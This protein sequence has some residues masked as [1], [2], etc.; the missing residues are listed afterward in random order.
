MRLTDDLWPNGAE[1]ADG[2]DRRNLLLLTQLR[3]LAALGQIMTILVVHFGVGVDLPLTQMF[4]MVAV[5]AAHNLVSLETY[6]RRIPLGKSRM[7]IELLIDVGAF[8]VQIY[9]SGG[10]TNP[11]ITLFLLQVIIGSILLNVW[12]AWFLF[13]VAA[14][15]FIVLCEFY[16]PLRAPHDEEAALLNLHTQGMLFCF[17][18][19]SSLLVF[20]VTRMN[21]NLRA[22]DA[23]LAELRRRSAEEDHIV[24]MG[25]MASGAAHELGTPLATL[26]VILSDWEHMATFRQ[27]AEIAD[28]LAEMQAQVERCKSIVSGI[29]LSAGEV[30]G[31]GAARTTI[32]E[33]LDAAVNEWRT[34]R[35]PDHFDYQ[36]AFFPDQTIV[37]DLVIKQLVFNLLDNAL[38]ASPSWVGMAVGRTRD[39][40]SITVGD[41]GP[42]FDAAVLDRLGQPYNSTKQR[43]GAG[44]GLYLAANVAR[45]LGGAVAAANRPTGGAEV[46]VTLPLAVLKGNP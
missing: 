46:V 34:T 43:A 9:L 7:L 5:L 20:F 36:N 24:H 4:I 44:L 3:W 17:I 32:N 18:V 8:A 6:R 38:E 11:F 10:A 2:A 42:G 26:S 27:D 22:R 23:H 40:V 33:F 12:S 16:L 31:E 14:L 19:A 21:T 29:L 39:G 37:A 41:A 45:K 25:L 28:E 30:R 1:T 15:C 35:S 13:G